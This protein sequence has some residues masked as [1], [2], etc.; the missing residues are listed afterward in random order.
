M[1]FVVKSMDAG[2]APL[3]ADS[4]TAHPSSTPCVNETYAHAGP[5]LTYETAQQ[6]AWGSSCTH[7]LQQTPGSQT[8]S[9][10]VMPH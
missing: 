1:P 9:L 7:A 5:D 8:G 2:T 4:E 3:K 6:H 10:R